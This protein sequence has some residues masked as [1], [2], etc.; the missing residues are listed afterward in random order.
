MK[1]LHLSCDVMAFLEFIIL[2]VIAFVLQTQN[3]VQYSFNLF[4][5][6]IP[7]KGLTFY[8]IIVQLLVLMVVLWFCYVDYICFSDGVW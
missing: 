7:E 8:H 4:T 2:P 5:I 3:D 6:S 1:I